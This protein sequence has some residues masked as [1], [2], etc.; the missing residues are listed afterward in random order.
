MNFVQG[1]STNASGK[2]DA[3]L[4]K[5]RTI[6]SQDIK[7]VNEITSD[8]DV[9][10]SDIS[11]AVALGSTQ[12]ANPSNQAL[13]KDR[14]KW[15]KSVEGKII[16]ILGNEDQSSSKVE[17]KGLSQLK[18]DMTHDFK[19]VLKQGDQKV[20]QNVVSTIASDNTLTET[21]TANDKNSKAGVLD[22]NET[23]LA[24][25]DSQ[26]TAKV[27]EVAGLK[28]R[29]KT[30]YN[31][32]EPLPKVVDRMVLMIKNGEQTGK[33]IIQPPELG[34]STSTLP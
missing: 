31:L 16:N 23:P 11:K 27:S 32:P 29:V 18:N 33:L 8:S 9:K 1:S 3:A 12:D 7:S 28:S 14:T 19:E 6:Q 5:I 13:P 10:A 26:N 22:I 20:K 30:A 15:E 4:P 25:L 21:N 17:D 2:E 24:G 34:K